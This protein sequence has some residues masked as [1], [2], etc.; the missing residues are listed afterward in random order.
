LGGLEVHWRIILRWIKNKQD[1]RVW[2]SI[3]VAN[4]RG[5]KRAICKHDKEPSDS[6]NGGEIKQ[7][8]INV[9]GTPT[10]NLFGS[11]GG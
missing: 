4:D 9:R 6:S 7:M 5:Q 11:M 1:M 3:H 2:T 8:S 10:W